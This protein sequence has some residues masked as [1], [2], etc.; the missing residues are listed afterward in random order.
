MACN[1]CGQNK[2]TSLGYEEKLGTCRKCIWLSTLGACFFWLLFCTLFGS[3]GDLIILVL[4]CIFSLL[5][6]AHFVA[7]IS[8]K[9]RTREQQDILNSKL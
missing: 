1:T 3:K 2:I 8:K 5:V 4:A 7:Y 9:S 6:V